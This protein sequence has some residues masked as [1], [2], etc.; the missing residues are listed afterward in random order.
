MYGKYY[1]FCLLLYFLQ[2]TSQVNLC[3]GSQQPSSFQP[4]RGPELHSGL[5]CYWSKASS[6]GET[7]PFYSSSLLKD[8]IIIF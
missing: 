8:P 5:H 7:E 2:S 1:V 4:L 3:G 6:H